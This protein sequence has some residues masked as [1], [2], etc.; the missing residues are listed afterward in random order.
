MEIRR[1][2]SADL[3]SYF[4]NRLRALQNSPSAFLTTLEEEKERGKSHFAETLAHQANEKVILGAIEDGDVVGTIGLF[5]ESRPKLIH[6]AAI[7]GMY[8]DVDSRT[9]GVGGKLLDLAIQHAR[10]RMKVAAVYLSVE[11]KNIAAKRLYESRGFKVW[12]TEP[13]AMAA[14]GVFFEEDHMVLLLD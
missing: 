4:R 13:R 11:F 2:I 3:D 14:G 9:K 10:N 5:Q 7:W 8:V 6:K 1:L 12:G